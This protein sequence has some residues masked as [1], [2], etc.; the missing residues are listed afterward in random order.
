MLK[1]IRNIMRVSA[2]R[3]HQISFKS[4][5]CQKV[6]RDVADIILSYRRPLVKETP[7]SQSQEYLTSYV[8]Q[9]ILP[10]IKKERPIPMVI[11]GF[12]MKSASKQKVIS[13]HADRGEYE[14]FEHI[15]G[16]TQRIRGIYPAGSA[17][18]GDSAL[19]AR[20]EGKTGI[21]P[22]NGLQACLQR[23]PPRHL[24]EGARSHPGSRTPGLPL[25]RRLP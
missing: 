6:A 16:L 21:R 22:G 7:T 5:A 11:L 17:G 12:P 8:A 24:P 4:A 13:P 3:N 15:K 1:F 14:S 2:V 25:L 23:K 10:S 19:H 20:M 18:P 9:K